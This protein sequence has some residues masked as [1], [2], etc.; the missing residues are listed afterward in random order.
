VPPTQIFFPF[1]RAHPPPPHTSTETFFFFFRGSNTYAIFAVRSGFP[2]SALLFSL[3]IRT[4][5]RHFLFFFGPHAKH[6]P[7]ARVSYL[8]YPRT[9]GGCSLSRACIGTILY[10]PSSRFNSVCFPVVSERRL[11]PCSIGE[12][13]FPS[14]ITLD[15]RLDRLAGNT[16]P[17][18]PFFF[19][20]ILIFLSESAR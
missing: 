20:Y 19:T 10:E 16:E 6:A 18:G 5:P 1:F 14:S 8:F 17:P 9:T 7:L 15:N 11:S 3:I 12:R 4:R 13:T 2:A